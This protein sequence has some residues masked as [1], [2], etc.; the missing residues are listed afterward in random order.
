[1]LATR[2]NGSVAWMWAWPA[3][4]LECGAERWVANN[5]GVEEPQLRADQDG[6]R[7]RVG[8][9]AADDSEAKP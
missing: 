8:P 1:M 7:H 2:S 5:D 3:R 6:I 9:T 4:C